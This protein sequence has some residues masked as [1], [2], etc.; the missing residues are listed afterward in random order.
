MADPSAVQ[1]LP[2]SDWDGSLSPVLDAM[3]GRPLN[4]HGL[5][6]NHP[7]LLKAWW[8]L[9]MHVVKAS[10]LDARAAE[11][12][13]LRTAVH[14]ASQYEWLSHVDRGHAAGLTLE[15]IE[16]V[17]ERRMPLYRMA[18]AHEIDTSELT[19]G[20]VVASILEALTE[21]IKRSEHGR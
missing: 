17:M 12:V 3:N 9:R 6:A 15:E 4:V 11:L 5:I 10:E 1:A 7:A 20:E 13:I 2:P 19:R 8:D 21:E 18:A 16:R 14:A